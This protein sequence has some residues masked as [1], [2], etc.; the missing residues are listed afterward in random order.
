M[1]SVQLVPIESIII[2][3]IHH[4][5][6]RSGVRTDQREVTKKIIEINYRRGNFFAGRFWLLLDLLT[7][8]MKMNEMCHK[9]QLIS[10]NEAG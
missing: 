10:L 1:S 7:M 3:I 6:V 9:F 4:A 2:D 8:A 5:F